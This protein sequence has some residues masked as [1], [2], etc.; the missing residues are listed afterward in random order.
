MNECKKCMYHESYLNNIGYYP[1]YKL[2]EVH[3][4]RIY[5]KT[6]EVDGKGCGQFSMVGE[7]HD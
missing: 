4:C 1:E 6:E 2:V 7:N 5:P 3:V